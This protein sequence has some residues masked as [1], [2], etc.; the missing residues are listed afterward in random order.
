M[1]DL[2]KTKLIKIDK[3][4]SYQESVDHDNKI[5][6]EVNNIQHKKVILIG[7]TFIFILGVYLIW[8]HKNKSKESINNKEIKKELGIIQIEPDI[9]KKIQKSKTASILSDKNKINKEWINNPILSTENGNS[10]GEK[11]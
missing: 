2:K 1:I 7:I 10:T 8:E 5:I 11:D 4:K 3:E 9:F 6:E